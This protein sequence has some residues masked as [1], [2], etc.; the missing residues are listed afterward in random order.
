[1]WRTL[2]GRLPNELRRLGIKTFEEAN[3]YGRGAFLERFN[4]TFAVQPAVEGSAFVPVAKA[5]L[6]RIFSLRFERTV[7]NDHTTRFQNRVLQL[8]KVN[9]LCPLQ[10][11]RVE[12][13][14]SLDRRVSVY[15]GTRRVRPFYFLLDLDLG[16]PALEVAA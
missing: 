10:K 3:T 6:E 2:Q 16:D 8:D 13:R 15:L 7:G 14:L 9:G 4:R 11:R 1:M 12:L 5:D